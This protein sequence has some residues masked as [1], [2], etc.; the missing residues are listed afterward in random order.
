MISYLIPGEKTQHPILFSEPAWNAKPKR[1]K[2][3]EILFEKFDVPA[4]YHAKNAALA[5]FANGRHTGLV[6]DSGASWTAAVPVFDG[7][8]LTQGVVRTPLAG[9]FITRQCR[10]VLQEDLKVD[11]VPYYRVASKVIS[12]VYCPEKQFG[13]CFLFIRGAK[14]SVFLYFWTWQ[15]IFNS[16]YC[17]LVM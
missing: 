10:K 11:P 3:A 13:P 8:V 2:L 14:T 12:F 15:L 4:F 7:R 5:C 6:L 1:E 9:D 17:K 16:I